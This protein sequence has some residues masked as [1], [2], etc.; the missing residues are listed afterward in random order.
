MPS[1]SAVFVTSGGRP[2]DH[3]PLPR[4]PTYE[5]PSWQFLCEKEEYDGGPFLTYHSR[6]GWT[7]EEIYDPKKSNKSPEEVASFFQNWFFWGLLTKVMRMPIRTSDFVRND[8]LGRPVITTKQLPDLVNIW[9]TRDRRLSLRAQEKY[10]I[11]VDRNLWCLC[12]ILNDWNLRESS[13]FDEWVS[14]YIC[15]LGEYLQTAYKIIYQRAMGDWQQIIKQKF[16]SSVPDWCSSNRRWPFIGINV[17][18]R[19]MVTD[20]WCRSD[21]QRLRSTLQSY[22]FFYASLIK[23][24]LYE[25]ADQSSV[26]KVFPK[27]MIERQ[28]MK[29]VEN[30]NSGHHRC[31]QFVCHAYQ[32]SKQNYKTRHVYKSCSCLDMKID[33]WNV[34][35]ILAESEI[36]VVHIDNGVSVS[37]AIPRKP[38]VAI[39]HVWADG[40]GNPSLNALPSCQ[41]KRISSMVNSLHPD[42]N[43]PIPFWIDTICCPVEPDYARAAAI[44][45]MEKTYKEADKVLVLDSYLQSRAVAAIPDMEILLMIHCSRWNR[46]LWTLQERILAKDRIYFKFKDHIL[47]IHE[48]L[49]CIPLGVYPEILY[50]EGRDFERLF[51]LS[52]IPLR[53]SGLERGIIDDQS[54]RNIVNVAPSQTMARLQRLLPFRATSRPSDEAICVGSMLNLNMSEILS[55]SGDNKME[56]LWSM[57]PHIP[58]DVIFWIGPKLERKGF[59]WAPSTFL[60][61]RD[62]LINEM[63]NPYTATLTQRGLLVRYPGWMLGCKRGSKVKAQ[64]HI[65]DASGTI[66]M[67]SCLSNVSRQYLPPDESFNPWILEPDYTSQAALYILSQF[68]LDDAGNYGPRISHDALLVLACTIEEDIIFG[69]SLCPVTIRK[70]EAQSEYAQSLRES[71]DGVLVS[72]EPGKRELGIW[73][74][75]PKDG[76]ND[77]V[78]DVMGCSAFTKHHPF[79]ID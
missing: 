14:I 37:P 29:T 31:S 5:L 30:Q 70:L 16:I 58:P 66:Y 54:F 47:C 42:M 69:R 68:D 33:M 45:L 4:E 20:G 15:I 22:G 73:S 44:M 77:D 43:N 25:P 46:R 40:L 71:L 23:P 63:T 19:Q 59:R 50:S 64:F 13:P 61:G 78:I 51:F 79:C 75:S 53:T 6:Q 76:V 56:I 26:N 10:A 48:I 60:I 18:D 9:Y 34:I 39:S 52:W 28:M 38:Y 65:L 24:P 32:W 27:S 7:D 3:L 8:K 12:N 55:A 21:I 35:T 57:M 17:L 41:L 36:P 72:M 11:E 67:I 62:L 49:R 2:V 74:S 1:L